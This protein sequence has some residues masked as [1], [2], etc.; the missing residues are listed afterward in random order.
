MTHRTR[1]PSMRLLFTCVPAN[2]RFFP[3]AP[4]ARGARHRG[5]EVIVGTASSMHEAIEGAN[6]QPVPVGINI[7]ELRQSR[8]DLG[9]DVSRREDRIASFLFTNVW[10]ASALPSLLTIGR[11][12]K[13][14]AIIHEEGEFAGPLAAAIL[15]LP[16]IA[17]S[18]AGPARSARQWELLE[19]AIAPLWRRNGLEPARRAGLFR[20]LFLD[21][22]PAILQ[23][24]AF[25]DVKSIP[26]RPVPYDSAESWRGTEWLEGLGSDAIFVTLGTVPAFNNAPDVIR[27]IIE[28]LR[29]QPR[30]VAIAIGDVLRPEL[31]GDLP[32]NVHLTRFVPQSL[33]NQRTA[34]VICH[35]GPGTATCALRS[36][37]PLLLLPRGGA[38]QKRVADACLE[39][40]VA[41]VL[42]PAEVNVNRVRECV[43]D[44]IGNPS[45]RSAA[46]RIAGQIQAMPD[47]DDVLASIED[48][49]TSHSEPKPPRLDTDMQF[50]S[51]PRLQ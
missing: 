50:S 3:V 5:H 49:I 31:L 6:L 32:A 40:G 51:M 30:Q 4:L 13:P 25:T 36:A 17:V 27:T 14:D 33:V 2:G 47:P 20:T 16:S 37:I 26:M 24:P 46:A 18:W 28:A 8:T 42:A 34:L 7:D 43:R 23:D 9:P 48:A 21:T 44:L 45:C 10:P 11:K 1:R 15:R 38:V 29:D 35:A 19:G 22:C 41:R 12:W 39:A